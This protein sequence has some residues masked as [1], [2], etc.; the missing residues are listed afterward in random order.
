M[1]AHSNVQMQKTGCS[2]TLIYDR[3]HKP[4]LEFAIT[5][6]NANKMD[7]VYAITDKSLYLW[8]NGTLK[9]YEFNLEKIGQNIIFDL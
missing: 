8:H 2:N 1:M 9:Q 4:I 5:F 6:D 7:S 3:S